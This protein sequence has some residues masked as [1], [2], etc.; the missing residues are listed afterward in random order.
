MHSKDRYYI[1]KQARMQERLIV[2]SS[3]VSIFP[4]VSKEV[5]RQRAAFTA[6]KQKL[7]E[8]EIAYSMQFPAQL[9]VVAPMGVEFFNSP[10]EVW[11]WLD[12]LPNLAP[13]GP[14]QHRKRKLRPRSNQRVLSARINPPT[15]EE[16]QEERQWVV[17]AVASL[18]GSSLSN[19]SPTREVSGEQTDSDNDSLAS[20]HSS[21]VLPAVT[22]GT[23]NERI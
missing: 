20:S 23:A 13:S 15:A 18:G 4:D 16:V 2:D 11:S 8:L 6:A 22:P 19:M 14:S 1:L 12:L 7:S 5:H 21:V 9:R 3:R 17:A 10:Q